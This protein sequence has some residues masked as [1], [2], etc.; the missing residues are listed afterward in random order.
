LRGDL[1]VEPLHGLDLGQE[2]VDDV[3]QDD[4][5]EIHPLLGY[6][7]E[8]QV[9]RAFEDVGVDLVRHT[10]EVIGRAGAKVG[11]STA[12]NFPGLADLGQ[13]RAGRAISCSDGTGLLGG[14]RVVLT[15]CRQSL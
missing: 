14:G 2:G 3:S 5:V 9:E 1:E 6:Q 11:Y 4:L 8:Q 7:P 10:S 15:T 12:S 13:S